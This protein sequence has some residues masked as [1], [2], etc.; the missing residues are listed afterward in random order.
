MR[1]LI[2]EDEESIA[3]FIKSLLKKN[4]YSADI[5]KDGE[6][7]LF[8]LKTNDFD[9]VILDI[10]L[11]KISGFELCKKIRSE[12][13]HIPILVLSARDSVKD[14]VKGLD[15]GADDYLAKPFSLDELLARIRVLFRKSAGKKTGK[16]RIKDL[17]LDINKRE[18][19]KNGK[20]INLSSKEFAIFEY[21]V[22]RKDKV[23]SRAEILEHVWGESEENVFTNTVDVHVNYLRKK[24]G[25]GLIKTMRGFGYIF[26]T[27]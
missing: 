6:E 13:E 22:I 19:I 27:K 3:K 4:K 14:K 26:S 17:V 8:L 18:I 20:S 9:A 7:A 15:F 16:M 1:I 24:I 11:P 2:V 12:K 5:A 25:S 23:V 21:L 10:N